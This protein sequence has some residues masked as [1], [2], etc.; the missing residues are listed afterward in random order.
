MFTK[1]GIFKHYHIK[2]DTKCVQGSILCDENN[3]FFAFSR[4]VSRIFCQNFA[5]KSV[6]F[7][8][9]CSRQL[10][11]KFLFSTLGYSWCQKACRIAGQQDKNEFFNEQLCSYIYV[12]VMYICTI[13]ANELYF[14]IHSWKKFS[15]CVIIILPSITL[16]FNTVCDVF[17]GNNNKPTEVFVFVF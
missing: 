17:S 4:K 3:R 11:R 6:V 9:K 16:F 8:N 13:E 10:K 2:F 7:V 15:W 14:K 1:L 5:K 12:H